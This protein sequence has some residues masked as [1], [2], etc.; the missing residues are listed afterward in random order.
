MNTTSAIESTPVPIVVGSGV[1]GLS[2]ALN[3]GRC[4]VITKGALASGSSDFAQ[5]GIAAALGPD[6]SP[7]AHAADTVAVG[8]GMVDEL[9][10]A[11]VA[12]E[13]P[14][15][16]E[17]LRRLGAHFDVDPAGTLQLGREAGHSRSRIVH[18]DGD[19]TGSE[20]MDALRDAVRAAPDITIMEHAVVIDL[21]RS[22]TRIVG[23]VLSVGNGGPPRV[24]LA[25]AVVIATGGIGQVYSK[26]T[27]P[28]ESTGD[29]VAVAARAG[30]AL[31]DIEFVQF[32]PTAL[33]ASAD[34]LP[35]LTEALRG[36]GALLIDTAGQRFMPA[37]HPDA[38]LAPRDIVS[39]AVW[40]Q[41]LED[42][43]YLDVTGITSLAERFPTV[44]ALATQAGFDPLAE[45]LPV[46][47]AAHYHM[48]GIATDADG[49]SSLPGLYACGEVSAT[50][51]HGAN[52]LASNS[53]LEGLVFAARVAD[54]VTSADATVHTG[55]V[56]IPVEAAA[57]GSAPASAV[58]ELRETMWNHVGVVRNGEGLTAALEV[59][60][61]LTPELAISA[62][63]RSL[64]TVSRLVT[65][66]A[67]ARAESRGGHFRSDFPVSRDLSRAT[68]VP[69]A[70][71]TKTVRR[72]SIIRENVA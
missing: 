54:A 9:I 4:V 61:R 21:V 72:T 13:G 69:R 29:G 11:M 8:G 44:F 41:N 34:P 18:A 47:P 67:L 26:T 71:A 42:R 59:V 70:A 31:R 14:G 20:V 58:A 46:T 12:R 7:T 38:E 35:L 56:A 43:A 3:L 68:I 55:S 39:R 24:L 5:G 16:I 64:A 60:E 27:N 66:Q 19:A 57:D 52:R 17:W 2:A 51:L 65:T 33:D 10:A 62:T 15:R 22:D 37:V 32:H 49:R 53:L 1:A 63:G 48:G 36:A 23:V 28:P 25:P 6:D 40:H 50:G 30:A 45:P